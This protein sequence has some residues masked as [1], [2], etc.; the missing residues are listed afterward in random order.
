M[1]DLE[2]LKRLSGMAC[3]SGFYTPEQWQAKTGVD[4]RRCRYIR[5][6]KS[7]LSVW[8]ERAERIFRAY[9]A[10]VARDW[11]ALGLTNKT[12]S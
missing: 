3:R 1:D 4:P 8:T 7:G 11:R 10:D 6:T 5:H 2:L 12:A 9:C